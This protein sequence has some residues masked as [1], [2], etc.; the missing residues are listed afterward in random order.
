MASRKSFNPV[1]RV[2]KFSMLP[3]KIKFELEI[4]LNSDI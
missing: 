4:V 3:L 1:I 2:Q